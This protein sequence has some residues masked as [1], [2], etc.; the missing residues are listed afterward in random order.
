MFFSGWCILLVVLVMGYVLNGIALGLLS[1]LVLCLLVLVG[2]IK[3]ELP[4]N[5]LLVIQ[6]SWL[7]CMSTLEAV[8]FFGVLEKKI[9]MF[10]S[11]SNW[12][13]C[14]I[15]P[16]LSY[17]FVFLTGDKQWV[18]NLL[19]K[20]HGA[21]ITKYPVQLFPAMISTH[22]ALLISPLYISGI[23]FLLV[24]SHS[25]YSILNFI[26]IV[27]GVSLLIM[28]IISI[29]CYLMSF[30]L[31]EKLNKWCMHVYDRLVILDVNN[32]CKKNIY[33]VF[34]FV[35]LCLISL[36][37]FCVKPHNKLKTILLFSQVFPVNFSL[38]IALILLAISTVAMLIFNIK[39]LKI[40]QAN[41]FSCGI[42]QFFVF[43]GVVWLI[44][45]LI[46]NDILSLINTFAQ[47]KT[48]QNGIVLMI[49]IFFLCLIDMPII[50]WVFMPLL[51]QISM[52]MLKLA[53][54]LIF[55]QG[56]Q[57]FFWLVVIKIRHCMS[58]RSTRMFMSIN[59]E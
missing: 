3:P 14:F 12:Y 54:C 27:V 10:V 31:F 4:P 1:G 28:F 45:S 49:G 8:G 9:K 26:I 24:V 50:I 7:I 36:I 15:A 30:K 25:K 33:Y 48:G 32:Q 42:K 21:S 52:P 40:I 2:K 58:F 35:L 29:G 6:A 17:G 43:L 34:L 13:T 22:I 44:E 59:K 18:T 5:H 37:F 20:N 53:A 16:I 38:F 46:A 41:R 51:L 11:N 56:L 47:F 39:P 55:I 57:F 19:L 23:L